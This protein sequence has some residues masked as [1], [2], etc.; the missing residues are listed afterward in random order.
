MVTDNTCKACV[1][2]NGKYLS[3]RLNNNLYLI[4][5]LPEK[6]FSNFVHYLKDA[7]DE[8]D[9]LKFLD[10]ESK[11]LVYDGGVVQVIRPVEVAKKPGSTPLYCPRN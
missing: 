2:L 4:S 8:M 9:G 3:P 1:Q 11:L 10:Y 6:H 5:P 7:H